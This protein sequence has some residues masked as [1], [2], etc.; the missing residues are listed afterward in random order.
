LFSTTYSFGQTGAI[1]LAIFRLDHDGS[2]VCAFYG[3]T[4]K[5]TDEFQIVYLFWDSISGLLGTAAFGTQ[6]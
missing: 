6:A 3:P 5:K 4:K 1:P 2:L